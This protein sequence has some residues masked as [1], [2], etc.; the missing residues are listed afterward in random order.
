MS[1]LMKASICININKEHGRGAM[2]QRFSRV[3]YDLL[4]KLF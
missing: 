2:R 3:L 4:L 1:L